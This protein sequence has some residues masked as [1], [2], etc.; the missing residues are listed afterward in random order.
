M[1]VAV[2]GGIDSVALLRL[3]LEL[4]HELGVVLSVVHFNHK[5]R[6][7]ESDVDE[8]FVAGLAREH[9]LEFH[10]DHDDVAEHAREQRI[11]METAARELRYGFFRHLLGNDRTADPQGLKPGSIV[12]PNGTAEAVPFPNSKAVP[13]PTPTHFLD[14]IVTGHTLDDQAETVLMRIIRG[15]GLRG[16]GG[17]HPRIFVEDEDG[18]VSGE[19]IRPL[20]GIRRRELEQYL[21]NIRQPWREDSTNIDERFTRNRVRKL[22]VPLLQQEFN[23]AVAENLTELAE[24]ARGEEDYWDNEISGWMGT[25]VHWSQPEWARVWPDRDG[26]V[27][28]AMPGIALEKSGSVK[29]PTSRAKDAREMGHPGREMGHRGEKWGTRNAP[30]F[31]PPV[32]NR[33]G[34]LA[35]PERVGQPPVAAGRADR[36]STQAGKG[37]RRKCPHSARIQTCGR[38]PAVRGAG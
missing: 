19:I 8:Q 36:R 4:R 31:R 3:L 34:P 28:I 13:F 9:D 24:I 17:I 29:D 30:G 32:Q 37:D 14:K 21:Q 22:L 15:A 25:T 20:L 2:S 27:Q 12:V 33:R 10:V 7:A 38:N 23:P 11:S 16:L 35:S 6:G 1:G 5:L 26:L 18:N